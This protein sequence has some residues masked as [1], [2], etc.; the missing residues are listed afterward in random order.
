MIFI[1]VFPVLNLC[2]SSES[3]KKFRILVYLDPQN[4]KGL[5]NT[6]TGTKLPV[7]TKNCIRSEIAHKT[8]F[9]KN[10]HKFKNVDVSWFLDSLASDDC[11]LDYDCR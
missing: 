1:K 9:N 7:L 4:F 6:G 10:T 3:N 8:I 11:I 5:F 2:P